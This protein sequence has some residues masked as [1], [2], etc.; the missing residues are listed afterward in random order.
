MDIDIEPVRER[1]AAYALLRVT[2]DKFR[3]HARYER[4]AHELAVDAIR[5][6]EY[7]LRLKE[8]I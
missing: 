8:Q 1:A 4:L 6:V 2:S 7:L 3:D 5:M